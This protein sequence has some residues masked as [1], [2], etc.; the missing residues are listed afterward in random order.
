MKRKPRGT[1]QSERGGMD[2][3]KTPWYWLLSVRWGTL[4]LPRRHRLSLRISFPI[5]NSI[6]KLKRSRRRIVLLGCLKHGNQSS[7]MLF[8]VIVPMISHRCCTV[9]SSS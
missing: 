8:D 7:D 4:F 6:Q 2:E 1:G 3:E 5:L 9:F